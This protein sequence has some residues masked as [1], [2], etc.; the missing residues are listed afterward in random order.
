[1]AFGGT[2]PV[3]TVKLTNTNPNIIPLGIVVGNDMENV[4]VARAVA[5]DFMTTFGGSSGLMRKKMNDLVARTILEL[6]K[7]TLRQYPR[8]TAIYNAEF[9]FNSMEGGNPN[10][11]KTAA[12]T[13]NRIT[14]GHPDLAF[15]SDA[16][17]ATAV[18]EKI[19]TQDGQT[20][21]FE[22][23]IIGTAVIEKDKVPG[24][25]GGRQRRRTRR[26]RN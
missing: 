5:D 19:A 7:D 22:L 21:K 13:V 23:A 3:Y 16:A 15:L 17:K 14:R 25:S 6:Q 18:G 9:H 8:A 24:Y 2:L 20:R 1:M 11:A 10:L 12:N 4:S 26:H